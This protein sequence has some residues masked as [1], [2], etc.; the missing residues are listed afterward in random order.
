MCQLDLLLCLS[1]A[2]VFTETWLDPF[3]GCLTIPNTSRMVTTFFFFLITLCFHVK[4]DCIFIVQWLYGRSAIPCLGWMTTQS[5]GVKKSPRKISSEY[6][7]L[8][9][10][11]SCKLYFVDETFSTKTFYFAAS[12]YKYCVCICVYVYIYI[13]IYIYIYNQPQIKRVGSSD[14]TKSIMIFSEINLTI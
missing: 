7:G 6:G 2:N 11:K 14:E 8:T 5:P 3:V 12:L 9:F 10:C 4:C 1:G 13:Y